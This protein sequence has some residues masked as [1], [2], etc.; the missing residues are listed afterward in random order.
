MKSRCQK[1][2]IHHAHYFDRGISVCAEWLESFA[3]FFSVVGAR[4]SSEHTLERVDNDKGYQPGNVKWATQAE[5]NRNRTDTIK[6]RIG[7][8]TVCGAQL[9]TMCG[10]HRKTIYRW[11]ARG[12]TGEEIL[13][14]YS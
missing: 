12:L 13:S 1:T 4:P 6:I 3:S 7:T 14:R 10:V 11:I 9:A 5:Q 8:E 2:S